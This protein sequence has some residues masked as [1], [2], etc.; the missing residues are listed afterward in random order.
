MINYHLHYF[1]KIVDSHLFA[2]I[3]NS[4]YMTLILFINILDSYMNWCASIRAWDQVKLIL[5]VILTKVVVE[6]VFIN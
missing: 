4:N 5:I 1:I 3:Y 2:N 6:F